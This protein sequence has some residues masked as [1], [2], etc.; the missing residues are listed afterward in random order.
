MAS[1]VKR[2]NRLPASVGDDVADLGGRIE[3]DPEAVVVLDG[4]RVSYRELWDA[5]ARV[6]GGL[7]AAGVERGDRSRFGSATGFDWVLGVLRHADGRR[8]L[9]PVNTRFTEPEVGYV[10]DDSGAEVHAWSRT[11]RCRTASRSSG[12]AGAGR[13]RGDLLHVSGTTGFPK[14]AMTTHENFL[15]NTENA[16][17]GA[18]SCPPTTPT[19]QPH[20]GAAVP[21]HRLQQ[22]AAARRCRTAAR[23]VIMPTFEV[24][25]VPAARSSRSGSR[26]HHG[27]GHLLATP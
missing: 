25:A 15:T 24:Q 6:A 27:A 1:G 22:P 14:G 21:R 3:P 13:T 4:P 18:C 11:P 12:R 16:H 7:R 2:Y 23:T 19:A 17:A 20:H 9:V 8:G 26:A 5:A 10:V